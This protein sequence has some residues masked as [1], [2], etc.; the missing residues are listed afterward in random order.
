MIL[1]VFQS[2]YK[3]N[4]VYQCFIKKGENMD[5]VV[6]SLKNFTNCLESIENVVIFV[7]VSCLLKTFDKHLWFQWNEV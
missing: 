4:L 2:S 6:V 7:S 3:F 1:F 5:M